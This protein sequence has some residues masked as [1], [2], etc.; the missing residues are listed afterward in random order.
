MGDMM[1][2][3]LDELE[4]EHYRRSEWVTLVSPSGRRNQVNVTAQSVIDT[5][6]AAGWTF[7]ADNNPASGKTEGAGDE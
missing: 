5:L 7:E 2:N 1:F 3:D 4:R 6:L